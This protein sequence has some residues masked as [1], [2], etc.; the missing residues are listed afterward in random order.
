[1]NPIKK[2]ARA[3]VR[4]EIDKRIARYGEDKALVVMAATLRR[5][6]SI[7][8][9]GLLD[10]NGVLLRYLKLR[11]PPHPETL[12]ALVKVIEPLDNQDNANMVFSADGEPGAWVYLDHLEKA[13]KTADNRYTREIQNIIT[14][15]RVKNGNL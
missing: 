14:K 5:M 15:A 12:E 11:K 2:K 9:A 6:G 3:I 7:S 13:S 8:R 10:C 1:M 4:K